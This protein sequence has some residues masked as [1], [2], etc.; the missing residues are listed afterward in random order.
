FD[1]ENHRDNSLVK[2]LG[3]QK[4]EHV[5]ML[6][7][8]MVAYEPNSRLKSED[9]KGRL[10]MTA[11]LVEGDFAPLKP[12]IK[13][14]CRFCGIGSY[15]KWS[16]FDCSDPSKSHGDPSALGIKRYTSTNLRVLRC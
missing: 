4:F 9:L 6:L 13:I 8:H 15:E 11:S 3:H 2:L 12:S 16:T 1:R 5:H 14:R 7:D 10:E